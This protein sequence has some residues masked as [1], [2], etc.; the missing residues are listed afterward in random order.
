MSI[1]TVRPAPPPTVDDY[2]AA[3]VAMLDAA[4]ETRRYDNGLSLSTYVGST[5]PAW[6]AEAQAYVA[7]RDGVW[8]YCYAELDKV[9]A[10][11]RAQPTVDE[12][13]AELPTPPWPG[14]P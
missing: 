6:A 13:L 7:W 2:K 5:N 3:I 9:L 4:A 1:I 14:R 12:F 10:G 8:G 11:E